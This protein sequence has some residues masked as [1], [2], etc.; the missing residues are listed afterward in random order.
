M[1]LVVLAC[2]W[3]LS[4]T[5]A[6]A[7]GA[8]SSAGEGEGE[9]EVPIEPGSVIV[10]GACTR[11]ADCVPDAQCLS[12]NCFKRAD[13]CLDDT[14]AVR[15]R[16][17]LSEPATVDCGIWGGRCAFEGCTLPVGAEC[18]GGATCGDDTDTWPCFDG[19]CAERPAE[20]LG[21]DT[22]PM[23]VTLP[24][25]GRSG[26]ATFAVSTP[27]MIAVRDVVVVQHGRMLRSFT[28]QQS[29]WVDA[30]DVL[31][32][33]YSFSSVEMLD[34]APLP[35]CL[36]DRHLQVTTGVRTCPDNTT[37]AAVLGG[38]PSCRAHAGAPCEPLA[39]TC[40]G[41]CEQ[42]TDFSAHCVDERSSNSGFRICEND[43]FRDRSG[44]YPSAFP[45]A[46]RCAERC[47]H[48]LG[49]IAR[50]GS[51]C[52]AFTRCIDPADDVSLLECPDTGVC[53]P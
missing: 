32:S 16:T 40:L 28:S 45:Y 52:G 39:D 50:A 41:L 35:R 9:G 15:F 53:P 4:L 20:W 2:V 6:C 47:E 30:G 51:A 17:D 48:G 49:C 10:G 44:D 27:T 37:C 7:G 11:D 12:G 38:V 5:P 43:R 1:R 31:A 26:N 36:D 18:T 21:G 22:N 8:P 46:V 33:V 29:V 13:S 42:Q 34:T 3:L 24:L 23:G 19:V 25:T 14:H